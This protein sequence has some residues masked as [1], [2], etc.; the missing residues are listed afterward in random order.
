MI[1]KRF[2][3]AYEIILVTNVNL[4][5]NEN[6]NENTFISSIFSCIPK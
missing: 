1:T 5:E 6:E 4:D 3:I 2:A